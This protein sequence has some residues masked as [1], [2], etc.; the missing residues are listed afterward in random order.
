MAS[1]RKSLAL[2]FAAKY[3]DLAI[4]I[5]TVMIIA[6]LLTPA[7]IGVYSVGMAV[8]ALAHVVRD[9]GVGNYR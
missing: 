9:F 7:E 6:R 2:S 3:T 5:V 8:A 1:I 4:S